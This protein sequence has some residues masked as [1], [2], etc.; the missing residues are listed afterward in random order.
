MN[1]Y[2]KNSY[3]RTAH[4]PDVKELFG[5]NR[6][7]KW[8]EDGLPSRYIQQIL[9][10]VDPIPQRHVLDVKRNFQLRAMA[11]CPICNEQKGKNSV[12]IPI[13]RLHQHWKMVH[14]HNEE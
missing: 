6:K 7:A 2:L 12:A 1:G 14:E 3:G 9:C 4:D 13:G 8:P 10:W 5:L 11:L